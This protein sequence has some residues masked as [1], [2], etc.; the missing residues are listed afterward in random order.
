MGC[1]T[2]ATAPPCCTEGS[3]SVPLE[4]G[5]SVILDIPWEVGQ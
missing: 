5:T 2:C 3:K 4:K 1:T